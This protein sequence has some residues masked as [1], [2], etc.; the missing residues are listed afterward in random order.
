MSK[1]QLL[2]LNV[3]PEGKPPWL[4]YENY[5][6]LGQLFEATNLPE[7]GMDDN[8]L[9]L[10]HFLMATCGL[11]IPQN[12][13]AIH[14]NAFTMLRRGYKVEEITA[15]EYIDLVRLLDGLEQPAKTDLELYDFGGHR[16]LYN[17][18]TRKM[19]LSVQAGRGPVW[20]RAKALV[21]NHLA[22]EKV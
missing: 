8:Y 15:Q 4:S 18:L 10:H 13:A 19:G 21:E 1:E 5:L 14:S 11:N 22:Q 20:Y 2:K 7:K 9:A 12:P 6:R 3:V 16:D 17:Y